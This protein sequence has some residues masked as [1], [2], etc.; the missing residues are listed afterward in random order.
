[1]L[2]AAH[3]LAERLES[4]DSQERARASRGVMAYG[5]K[6]AEAEGNR[7]VVERLN[8]LISNVEE[9]DDFHARSPHVPRTY[10]QN[11]LSV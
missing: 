1:M 6:V 5:L 2:K 7:R 10:N 4:E 8:R 11:S 9:E 3:V